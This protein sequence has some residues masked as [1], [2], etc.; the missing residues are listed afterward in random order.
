MVAPRE[1]IR[2]NFNEA[3]TQLH[4]GQFIAVVKCVSRYRRYGG[5]DPYTDD[6]VRNFISSFPR[7]D[8][9]ISIHYPLCHPRVCRCCCVVVVVVC[10]LSFFPAETTCP[11]SFSTQRE[12]A[13]KNWLSK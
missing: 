11:E 4:L 5:I 8:E 7:I 10:L 1:G 9:D 12:K 6:I 3:F 13:Q 2:S